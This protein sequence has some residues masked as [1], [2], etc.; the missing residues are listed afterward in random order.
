M[1]SVPLRICS[2]RESY[3]AALNKLW[4]Y[5]V[6]SLSQKYQNDSNAEFTGSPSE[7]ESDSDSAEGTEGEDKVSACSVI[8]STSKIS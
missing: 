3:W 6:P 8:Y 2:T 5:S 1:S 7:T 4:K